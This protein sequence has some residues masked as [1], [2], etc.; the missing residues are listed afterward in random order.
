MIA[1]RRAF[2]EGGGTEPVPATFGWRTGDGTGPVPTTFAT[3]CGHCVRLLCKQA[4]KFCAD[5]S[6]F[7]GC[8]S[9]RLIVRS[10]RSA[11]QSWLAAMGD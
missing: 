11:L 2:E 4:T 7:P 3:A 5:A 1:Q 6:R 10:E 8:F 9:S